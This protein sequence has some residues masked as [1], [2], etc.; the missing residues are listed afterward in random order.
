MEELVDHDGLSAISKFFWWRSSSSHWLDVQDSVRRLAMEL[1]HHRE[2]RLPGLLC[3]MKTRGRS[4]SRLRY[5]A[6]RRAELS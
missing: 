4:C 3:R 5:I 1:S 2:S 6:I